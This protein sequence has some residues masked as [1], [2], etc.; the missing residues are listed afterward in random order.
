MDTWRSMLRSAEIITPSNRTWSQAG[1]VSA[2]SCIDGPWPW[3]WDMLCLDPVQSNSV[4]SVFSLSLLAD[5][6]RPTST[7][8]S[9]SRVAAVVMSSRQQCRYNCVSS[10]NEWRVTP[11]RLTMSARSATYNTNSTG[12]RTEPCG[13]KQTN[14]HKGWGTTGVHD[15]VCPTGQ[16][17]QLIL[18]IFEFGVLLFDYFVYRQ[19]VTGLKYITR[20]GHYAGEVEDTMIDSRLSLKLLIDL[21]CLLL[22]GHRQG[23]PLDRLPAQH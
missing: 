6:Q 5:I 3:S 16:R 18:R 8:H 21:N 15:S 12:P 4:L 11:C 10:A 13:T 22:I 7:M 17:V 20:Y 2:P 14:V 9:L 1:T 23:M 19:N